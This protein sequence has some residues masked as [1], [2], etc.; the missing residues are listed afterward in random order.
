MS[1]HANN[2][3]TRHTHT[4][5]T[6][7]PK[8][9]LWDLADRFYSKPSLWPMIFEY[10]NL[11]NIVEET[12]TRILDPD[13]I[14]IGQILMIPDIGMA[15]R[16]GKR[17]L[18]EVKH[19][20][21]EARQVHKQKGR[22][23]QKHIRNIE[24]YQPQPKNSQPM[25]RGRAK[26]I[27]APAYEFDLGN[28]TL[29]AT[30]GPGFSLTAKLSGKLL[31]QDTRSASLK[32][33]AKGLQQFQASTKQQ[34]ET[35]A[36]KLINDLKFDVDLKNRTVKLSG[37][38]ATQSN[39]KGAPLVKMTASVTYDVVKGKL[40]H[41]TVLGEKV[42]FSIEIGLDNKIDQD[43]AAGEIGAVWEDLAR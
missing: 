7:L 39:I 6:V 18:D 43:K 22:Q 19:N 33:T 29:A 37:G 8:D 27:A 40:P 31:L 15:E 42:T 35:A 26:K 11:P 24:Q 20:I 5:Y 21:S 34:T 2:I 36:G 23:Q 16:Y 17:G 28:T 38:I 1:A 3:R 14:L 10:S 32:G 25:G 13:L 30:K 12:G 41:H 4:A 9:C